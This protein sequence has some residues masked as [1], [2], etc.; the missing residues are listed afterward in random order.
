MGT[1]LILFG[2]ICAAAVLAAPSP[3]PH[4]EPSSRGVFVAKGAGYSF[5]VTPDGIRIGKKLRLRWIGSKSRVAHGEELLPGN[6]HYFLGK[7]PWAWVCDVPHYARVRVRDLYP[8]VDAVYYTRDSNLE[9][10]LEIAP[11]ADLTPVRMQMA[12]ADSMEVDAE[13]TLVLRTASQIVRL[14]PPHVYQEISGKNRRVGASYRLRPFHQAAFALD[15]Y[16]P[17]YPVIIDPVVTVSSFLGG[18]AADTANAVA[19]DSTGNIYIAGQSH[20]TNFPAGP[21]GFRSGSASGPLPA[22]AFVTKLNPA[23][24]A[25]VYSA[26]FGG[27]L[28]D[29]VTAIVVDAQGNVY[30]VGRTLSRDFPVVAGAAQP[31]SGDAGVNGDGFAAKL[32][33]DGSRLIYSTLLGGSGTDA[34]SAIAVSPLGE[35]FLTGWT[36]SFNF[37]VS[38]AALQRSK[39]FGFSFDAFVTRLSADGSRFLYSTYLGGG[40]AEAGHAIASDSSGNAYVAGYTLSPDFPTTPGAFQQRFNGPDQH[41]FRD[42]FLVRLNATGSALLYGSFLGGSRS[43]TANAIALDSQ[44]NVYLAGE[45]NS[46]N[47]PVTA[48]GLQR[49]NRDGGTAQEAFVMKLDPSMSRQQWSTL[50]GGRGID[51]AHALKV[52]VAGNVTVA[53]RSDSV[54]FPVR[55][56][57]CRHSILQ[58]GTDAFVAS[59]GSNGDT[60][61]YSALLGGAR[62]DAALALALD[63]SG[64]AIVAGAAAS[65][66]F[67]VTAGVVQIRRAGR[68]D[69]FF[70]RLTLQPAVAGACISQTGI[71]GSSS[72]LAGPVAP[73]QLISVFGSDIGP[74]SFVTAVLDS[75]GRL[76]TELAQTRVTFDGVAAPLLFVHHTQI[77]AIV[78]YS[79]SGRAST[80]VEIEAPGGRSNRLHIPV[81]PTAP[82]IFT[83]NATGRGAGAILNEDSTV[84]SPLN[85][86]RPGSILI[87]YATGEGQ[88]DPPGVDGQIASAVFPV[89]T[90]P[91]SL[92]IGGREAVI[93]YA[94]AAPSFVAGVL[95]VNARIPSDVPLGAAVP[96]LLK[97]GDALSQPGVT[98]A[99][100]EVR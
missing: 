52:D 34:V 47:F 28:T 55:A 72:F 7:D 8:G 56:S 36:D 92:R 57:D 12:G 73:G 10:D 9:F 74:A 58:G 37:P 96:V 51:I 87:L 48:A 40:N 39:D 93:L 68:D 19:V 81:A 78:P 88:T 53:G 99:I 43:D 42:G 32:S 16:D 64:N 25:I 98:V 89:P 59:L 60:L 49:T 61:V 41:L 90:A 23:G 54:D 77:G 85:P 69:S 20:S 75:N 65:A 76:A 66:D 95:Q 86:A 71:L 44:S 30:A 38:E 70:A 63:S 1:S 45:T 82:G 21:G 29:E 62:D 46:V 83:R 97:I 31:A 27:S 4:F 91:V 79:V 50:L 94:G 18:D 17:L 3:Q 67:P 35:A 33:P 11:G 14:L 80:A 100:Q 2:M 26:V 15:E 24:T 6:S 13:G 84:N 22:Q 5:D